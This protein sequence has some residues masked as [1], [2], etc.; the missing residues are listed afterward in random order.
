M[1]WLL[2]AANPGLVGILGAVSCEGRI[3]CLLH[4]HGTSGLVQTCEVSVDTSII[5]ILKPYTATP[6][7]IPPYPNLST[8][9][10]KQWASQARQPL[11]FTPL[12]LHSWKPPMTLN[13]FPTT[14]CSHQ[15]PES[16]NKAYVQK[17]NW[18]KCYVEILLG[19]LELHLIHIRL[20][21]LLIDIISQILLYLETCLKHKKYATIDHGHGWC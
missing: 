12:Q 10:L 7:H 17:G 21:H 15:L 16:L 2:G 18:L 5:L 14:R 4:Y 13:T 20:L 9:P 11:K 6:K 1:D 3:L 8:H 19:V